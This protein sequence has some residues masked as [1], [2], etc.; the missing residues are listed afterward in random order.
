M[1][2][3]KVVLLLS[4][5]I[6]LSYQI[7]MKIWD[8]PGSYILKPEDY[9]YKPN[10]FIQLWGA[11]S[12]SSYYIN[13]G[14]QNYR[15]VGNSGA[16]IAA[17]ISTIKNETFYFNIG[18][19]GNCPYYISQP[20]MQCSPYMYIGYNGG[21]SVFNL[22]DNSLLFNVS[23][24]IA[25]YYDSTKG[26]LTTYAAPIVT[27]IYRADDS[28]LN[29]SEG[30]LGY[31][32]YSGGS[33]YAGYY[34]AGSPFGYLGGY[35][36]SITKTSDCDGFRGSGSGLYCNCQPSNSSIEYYKGGDGALIVYY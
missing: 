29:K 35:S 20:G 15:A 34:G 32:Y 17:N 16:Y 4:I 36:D 23:G 1:L 2:S 33:S 27:I 31:M 5:C 26:S 18:K 19:G 13:N 3:F 11:G 25:Y 10:I 9:D 28:I 7:E 14:G 21:N 22:P 12:G 30:Y 6:V 24:G 8:K